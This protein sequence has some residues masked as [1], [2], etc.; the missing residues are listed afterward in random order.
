MC[1]T[2]L[3]WGCLEKKIIVLRYRKLIC[4][5]KG[6]SSHCLGQHPMI[7]E[8]TILVGPII[9]VLS[10]PFKIHY[11]L[12]LPAE[13]FSLVKDFNVSIVSMISQH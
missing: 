4:D 8:N 9:L 5:L 10:N 11:K 12:R 1:S 13:A 3:D 7:L 2:N 6:D